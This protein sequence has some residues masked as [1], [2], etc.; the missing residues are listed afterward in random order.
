[1]LKI[2]SITRSSEFQEISKKGRKFHA[3]SLMLL[4]AP[5]SEFYL[6]NKTIGKNALDFARFGLTVS[7]KN[8]GNAVKRNQA[9]RRLREAV[10]ELFPQYAKPH[11]DYIIIAKRDIVSADFAKIISDLKFCLKRINS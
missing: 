10:R 1:M 3:A 7:A 5:T 6:Q 4:C 8:V 2:L 11:H 9:K